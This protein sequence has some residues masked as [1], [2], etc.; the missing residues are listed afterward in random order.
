MVPFGYFFWFFWV[1]LRI[2]GLVIC[3]VL[4]PLLGCLDR[5]CPWCCVGGFLNEA[6]VLMDS[7]QS[8]AS[9]LDTL[10]AKP[11]AYISPA[12]PI[13]TYFH[14]SPILALSNLILPNL[15]ISR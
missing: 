10:S 12:A 13:T 15:P 4:V 9:H 3:N 14:S 8:K 11:S 7:R 1:L 6:P 5:S 2:S